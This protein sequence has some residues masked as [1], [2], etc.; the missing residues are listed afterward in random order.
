MGKYELVQDINVAYVPA[1]SFP[2]GIKA[3]FEK[4]ENLIQPE[5]NRRLFGLSWPDKNGK[6]IYKAAIEEKYNGEAGIYG[7]N[8]FVIKR[9]SYISERV[10]NYS[11]DLSQIGE[12]FQRLLKYPEIDTKGYCLEWYEG[13]DDILCLVKLNS[14]EK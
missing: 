12:T 10:K 11:K 6:I 14:P 7:L 9:G 4:L 3:A 8:S 2:E 5:E 13:V 1:T